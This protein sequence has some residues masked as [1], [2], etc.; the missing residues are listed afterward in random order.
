[1]LTRVLNDL[2]YVFRYE[3]NAYVARALRVVLEAMDQHVMEKHIQISGRY[4]TKLKYRYGKY[5]T[6]GGGLYTAVGGW[7]KTTVMVMIT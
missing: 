3:N 7:N 6:K 2:Y 5:G 1:M 4:V